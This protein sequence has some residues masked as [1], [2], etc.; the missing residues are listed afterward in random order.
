[1]ANNMKSFEQLEEMLEPELEKLKNPHGPI[2]RLM[3]L[4][5]KMTRDDVYTSNKTL[6]GKINNLKWMMGLTTGI[7]VI[8]ITLINFLS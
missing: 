4:G 5:L 3:F 2:F 6:G 1:M 8:T 7:I